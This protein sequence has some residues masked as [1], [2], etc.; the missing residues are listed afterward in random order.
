MKKLYITAASVALLM[1]SAPY[2]SAQDDKLQARADEIIRLEP[3]A[4]RVQVR[5]EVEPVKKKGRKSINLTEFD[6]NKDGVLSKDEVGERLFKLFDRDRNHLIDN[7]EM[8]KVG[9]ITLS[10][11]KRKHI[12][13]VDYHSADKPS[14]T[15][16]TEEEF[17][18]R[19]R[20]IEFDK[21]EDGLSPL[22]FLGMHFNQ[23]DVRRDGVIDLYE[24]KRAYAA[25]VKP[26]HAEQFNYNN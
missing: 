22:D 5:E 13:I 1:V 8:K 24:W 21:D 4:K 11:M 23:V 20:L 15:T 6:L 14:K 10:P 19:S 12:E 16:V 2:A 25:S 18:Q 17:L 3:D 7:R 26:K 9:L